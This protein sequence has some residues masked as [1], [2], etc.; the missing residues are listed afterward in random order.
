VCARGWVELARKRRDLREGAYAGRVLGR[1]CTVCVLLACSASCDAEPAAD[2]VAARPAAEPECADGVWGVAE[3]DALA[4]G[5][6]ER[7][8]AVLLGSPSAGVLAERLERAAGSVPSGLSVEARVALQND[9]WGLVARVEAYDGSSA[10][11]EGIVR[12]GRS[13]VRAL[14]PSA[15]EL[16]RLSG[17]A[18]PAAV[19]RVLP[20]VDGW[21]ER[22]SEMPVLS[23][24]RLFG[25][26]RIFRVLERPGGRAL[27]SQLVALDD[28]GEP[29]LTSV[30]GEIEV[31]AVPVSG[32]PRGE[33]VLHLDRRALRCHGIDR[34]LEEVGVL[35]HL[36]GVGADGF[37]VELDPPVPLGDNP[38]ARCHE[39]GELPMSLPSDAIAPAERS[40]RLLEQVRR[41]GRALDRD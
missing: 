4:P 14:A 17:E 37:L 15:E 10:A 21:R 13:L 31:L 27:V 38:C 9:A 12:G 39:A 40:R 26:R 30:V 36:P 29:H 6:Y 11:R 16:R 22:G 20:A 1:A 24:E 28:A 34:S 5:I 18:L 2:E 32:A 41:T 8:A 19:A 7:D 23:H 25:L 35:A 33:R 3:L